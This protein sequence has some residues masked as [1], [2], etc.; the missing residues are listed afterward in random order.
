[1]FIYGLTLDS[2]KTCDDFLDFAKKINSSYSQYNFFT[3]YPSTPIYKE[4]EK[5]IISN[6]YEDFLQSNLVFKN[7]KLSKKDLSMMISKSYID[8]YLL[9]DYFFKMLKNLL[10]ELSIKI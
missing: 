4:Y 2:L 7:E 1:M 5:K 10:K 9:K 8:Y 6:K 3:S